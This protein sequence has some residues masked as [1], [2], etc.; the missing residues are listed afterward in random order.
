MYVGAEEPG[1]E[2]ITVWSPLVDKVDF[3]TSST[4][5]TVRD[6]RVEVFKEVE[7][8]GQYEVGCF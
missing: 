7:I 8:A 3:A 2:G 6:Q 4:T 5:N 1:F